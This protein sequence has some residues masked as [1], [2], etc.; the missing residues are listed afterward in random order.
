MYVFRMIMHS[1]FNS[2]LMKN[3]TET[4]ILAKKKHNGEN[5]FKVLRYLYKQCKH[6]TKEAF[7]VYKWIYFGSMSCMAFRRLDIF[8][9]SI[10]A[11][12][13]SAV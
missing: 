6:H 2:I 12:V 4:W 9:L 3:G 13:D 8:V 7:D 11:P 1:K 5:A 10:D